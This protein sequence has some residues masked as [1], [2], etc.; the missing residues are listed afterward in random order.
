[1]ENGGKK[2]DDKQDAADYEEFKASIK[3]QQ[4]SNTKSITL[5][6]DEDQ[7]SL[8]KGQDYILDGKKYTWDGTNLNEK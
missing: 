4:S 6:G 3:N 5:K 1:M 8:K 7:K 2:I